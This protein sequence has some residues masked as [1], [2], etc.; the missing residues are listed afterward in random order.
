MKFK[1]A[2]EK[3]TDKGL[4]DSQ[5]VRLL[6]LVLNFPQNFRP[7][8]TEAYNTVT[9]LEELERILKKHYRH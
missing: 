8:Q 6:A 2:L 3:L 4:D 5:R 7:S 9:D 1:K